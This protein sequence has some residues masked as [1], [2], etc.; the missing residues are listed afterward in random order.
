MHGDDRVRARAPAA[1]Y[2]ELL[3]VER[4]KRRLGS[5]GRLHA[6]ILSAVGGARS[7]A[8][9]STSNQTVPVEGSAPQLEA[10][11]R[12][13]KRPQPFDLSGPESAWGYGSKPSPPSDTSP[14]TCWSPTVTVTA[15]GV[16]RAWRTL[17][18]TSSV[19]SN[20]SFAMV[21][22]AR[23]GSKS[24]S[25]WRAVIGE[26]GLLGRWS[27][28]PAGAHVGYAGRASGEV[29]SARRARV[30]RAVG[31]CNRQPSSGLAFRWMLRQTR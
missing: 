1:A 15:I 26:S 22:G 21:S 2:D 25:R 29:L 6:A 7:P 20:R 18:A 13:R 30:R 5:L 12:T 8:Q 4:R 3:V 11:L 31:G 14:R 28:T 9:R 17:L 19:T 16:P 23:A 10:I 24:T 27:V